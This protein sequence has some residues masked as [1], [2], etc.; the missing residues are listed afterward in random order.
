MMTVSLRFER[1]GTAEG[2]RP[3]LDP[4]RLPRNLQRS[5]A[6]RWLGGRSSWLLWPLLIAGAGFGAG[7]AVGR[8]SH[9]G[10]RA[11]RTACGQAGGAWLPDTMAA[12][13]GLS[14]D[15]GGQRRPVR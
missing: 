6:T 4:R 11:T 2:V 10:P 3:S 7:F 1:G 9:A 12:D 13:P 14:N 5:D 15:G 8:A